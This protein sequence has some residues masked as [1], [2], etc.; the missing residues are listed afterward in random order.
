[1]EVLINIDVDDLDRAMTFYRKAL[2]LR[3][4]RR[5]DEDFVELEGAGTRIF[6]LRKP[7]A[8]RAV[9][10]TAER[11]HYER[12]WTPVHIDFVV[13]D[14]QQALPRALDAG[15]V[16]NGDVISEPWCR[17]AVLG[18]PFGH[19]FCLLEFIGGGYDDVPH[20]R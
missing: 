12:H 7:A 1:M 8:S 13:P 15:A 17:F 5:F 14:L 11:R 6:L 19:G 4:A 18:D 10:K 16:L 20:V 3:P 2:D 9:P